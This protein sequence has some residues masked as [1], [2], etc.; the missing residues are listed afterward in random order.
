VWRGNAVGLG[1][2]L[3]TCRFTIA[4][5]PT[6]GKFFVG[7]TSTTAATASTVDLTIQ[8]NTI[9]VGSAIGDT[10]MR[11]VI[12][13]ALPQIPAPTLGATFPRDITTVYFLTIYAPPN[14]NSITVKLLNESTGVVSNFVEST[15]LPANTTLFV[16]R[17]WCSNG[18]TAAAAA[19]AFGH[20]SLESD[21]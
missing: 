20:M 3:F 1:G 9:G 19:I 10:A 11:R 12:Q 6:N 5:I 17:I 7:L 13:G 15:T 18:G 21:I 2:F 14:G 4:T 16:P 8:A